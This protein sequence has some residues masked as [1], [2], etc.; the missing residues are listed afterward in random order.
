MV[1]DLEYVVVSNGSEILGN[2]LKEVK[3]PKK[4]G[5]IVLAMRKNSEEKIIFNPSSEV[6]LE[7]GDVMIVLGTEEQVNKLRKLACDNGK[8]RLW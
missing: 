7:L 1:L 3:I 2:S 4:I 5:L 8:Q 6:I